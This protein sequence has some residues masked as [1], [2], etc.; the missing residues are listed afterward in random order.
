MF[1]TGILE[2]WNDLQ[3]FSVATRSDLP[4]NAYKFQLMNV[5]HKVWRINHQRAFAAESEGVQYVSNLRG[6]V[7]NLVYRPPLVNLWCTL[8]VR[9]HGYHVRYS[10]N[11]R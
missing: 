3:S 11:V 4:L 6:R 1:L 7:L 9:Y 8:L 5:V 2:L 10:A